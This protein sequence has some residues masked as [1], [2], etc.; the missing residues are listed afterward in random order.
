MGKEPS[1]EEHRK[2]K[3]EIQTQEFVVR[4]WQIAYRPNR[5]QDCWNSNDIIHCKQTLKIL[6]KTLQSSHTLLKLHLDLRRIRINKAFAKCR[7]D[8]RHTSIIA[9]LTQNILSPR[10]L[11]RSAFILDTIS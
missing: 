1:L 5:T 3:V 11:H 7:R 4:E 2:R 8:L 10:K 9:L 6:H